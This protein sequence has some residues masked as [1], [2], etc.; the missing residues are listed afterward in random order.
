MC[1]ATSTHNRSTASVPKA[2]ERRAPVQ[3]GASRSLGESESIVCEERDKTPTSPK[4]PGLK[5]NVP[6]SAL[7]DASIKTPSFGTPGSP[8]TP[9][10]SAGVAYPRES[11]GCMSRV[12]NR[13][14]IVWVKISGYRPW[15]AQIV[16][17]GSPRTSSLSFQNA[18]SYKQESDDT[19]VTFFGTHDVAWVRKEKAIR[20]WKAGLKRR[21]HVVPKRKKSFHVAMDEVRSH[22]GERNEFSLA[23]I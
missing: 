10:F 9:L 5:T 6:S 15:P 4:V 20:P 18:K 13:E 2:A 21:F 11:Q 19:L 14:G 16:D 23:R 1:K 22:C 12:C 17:P 7:E 8:A 3:S